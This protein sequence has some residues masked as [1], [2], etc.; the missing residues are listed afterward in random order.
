MPLDRLLDRIRQAVRDFA[1]SFS[2]DFTAVAMR[3]L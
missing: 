3:G 2:D 1:G